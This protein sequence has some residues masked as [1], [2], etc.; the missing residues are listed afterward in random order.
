MIH[1]PKPREPSADGIR[2]EAFGEKHVIHQPEPLDPLQVFLAR[3]VLLFPNGQPH[4]HPSPAFSIQLYGY[5]KPYEALFQTLEACIDHVDDTSHEKKEFTD[6]AN[7]Q[8]HHHPSP[9]F[10]LA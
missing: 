3:V 10:I 8:P 2:L 7:G 5:G 9:A 4:H 6:K 1:G